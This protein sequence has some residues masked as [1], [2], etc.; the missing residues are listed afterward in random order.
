[1]YTF[2]KMTQKY[3]SIIQQYFPG[4]DICSTVIQDVINERNCPGASRQYSHTIFA[5]SQG[6]VTSSTLKKKKSDVGRTM[7]VDYNKL[8]VLKTITKQIKINQITT[9]K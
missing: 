6:C 1:M 3:I 4:L 9:M 2:D 5:P 7:N 8:I